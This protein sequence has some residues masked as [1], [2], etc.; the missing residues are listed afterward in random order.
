MQSSQRAEHNLALEYAI[1]QANRL[2]KPLVAFFGVKTDFPQANLRHF[3]FMLEG[4]REAQRALGKRGI[5]LVVCKQS[6]ELGAV[7]LAKDAA[8]VVVDRGYTK[9]VREFYRFVAKSIACPLVQVED[10]VVVPVEQASLKEDYSAA[11]LRPKIL[12]QRERFLV[13]GEAQKLKHPSLGLEL[14]SLSLNDLDEATSKLGVDASVP[15]SRFF[16]G[17]A[18]QAEKRLEGFLE[19]KLTAYAERKNDPTVDFVSNLSAYLHFGQISP[20]FIAQET[21]KADVPEKAKE[22]FLEELIVRRELAVNYVTYNPNYDAYESLPNWCKTTLS[23]HANDKRAA[24]YDLETLENARTHDPY[25][26][27]AQ[28]EMRV[29]GKMHGYMRMYWG[30][31]ILEWSRSPEMAFRW[32]L[33]LNDKY[34]LDGRDPNGYAG[35]AWCFGKHDRPWL[36]RPIFGMVRYMN[37]AGLKRKFN[38]DGYVEKVAELQNKK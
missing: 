33:Y 12:R 26:N 20:I 10:D 8:C 37:D 25:W 4:L 14:E 7:E 24:L 34:E 2:D 27:A 32:A 38:A 35:V 30:K 23:L 17:G 21:L 13:E 36:Q 3:R 9:P 29:T 5:N 11:T 15:P 18:S 19:N 16:V 31:K 28:Q 1:A 22:V 6:P